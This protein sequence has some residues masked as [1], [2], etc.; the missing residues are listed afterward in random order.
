MHVKENLGARNIVRIDFG[1]IGRQAAFPKK[2][3]L[4]KI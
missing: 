1:A 4:Q 2:A 3:G